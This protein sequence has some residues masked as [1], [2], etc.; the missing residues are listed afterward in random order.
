MTVKITHDRLEKLIS[1]YYDTKTDMGKLALFIWGRFG[2]GKS[3]IIK[4][5]AQDKAQAQN[6][7]FK[8]WNKSTAEEKEEMFNNPTKYFVLVDIRLSEYD[9]SD[10]KGLPI[11]ADNKKAIEF[12]IPYWSLYL[13]QEESDGILFFDEINL[14]SPLVMSSCYKIIY[15]RIVNDGKINNNWLILGAGNTT[16]DRAYTQEVAP[17]L[18]DRGGEV[19]LIGSNGEDWIKNFAIPNKIL[20][21]IIGYINYKESSLY[22]VDFNDEQKYTTYRGWERLSTLLKNVNK[23]DYET[24]ELIC[25]SAIGEGIA[26]EFLAFWK[27]ES[28]INIDEIIKNPKLI[29]NIKEVSIKYFLTSVLAEYYGNNKIDFKKLIEV[30]NVL[31]ELDNPEFV[32]LLWKMSYTYNKKFAN[33]F[34]TITDDKLITKYGSLIIK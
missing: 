23:K 30:T 31:D 19:E 15:D 24:I 8:E 16:E 14:A 22:N 20:S 27:I 9:S 10:I 28:E 18:R 33:D 29:K 1:H 12:K 3:A 5:V 13:E 2:I 32:A 21:Q 17:P 26:N 4:Q 25:T 34:I 11:F 7:I 6:K